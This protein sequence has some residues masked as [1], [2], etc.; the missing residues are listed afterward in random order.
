MELTQLKY[1]LA[2]SHLEHFTRAAEELHIS[3]PSLSKAISN[4]EDEL[5]VPLFDRD[6]RNV[7]LNGYGRAFLSHVESALA[8]LED[9]AEELKDLR[10]GPAGNLYIAS[11][12]LLDTPSRITPFLRQFYFDHPKIHIHV[13]YQD[14]PGMT[15][16]LRSRRADF[17]FS[18]GR[19]DNADIEEISLFSYHLGVIARKDDPIAA[20]ASVSLSE[21]AE[22][23]FLTNNSSPDLQDTIYEVCARAGFSPKIA[24]ECDNGDIIGEAISRGLGI[25]FAGPD[26]FLYNNREQDPARPWQNELTFVPVE[27]S[28]CRRTTRIAYLKGRYQ[29]TAARLF[30]SHLLETLC[31]GSADDRI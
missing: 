9:G 11:S 2:V 26:R 23:P 24:F 6:R 16:L 21:L 19:F 18:N 12:F 15:E 17:S 28:F 7:H 14:I 8:E 30:L 29:T 27:D 5:G 13:F 1:F 25:A 3:Q 22:Y 10:D 4:L 31:D 20:R